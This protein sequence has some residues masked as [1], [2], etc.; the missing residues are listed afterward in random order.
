MRTPKQ[1]EPDLPETDAELEAL[2]V[3]RAEQLAP[4][5]G[6]PPP[7]PDKRMARVPRKV[8]RL[9]GTPTIEEITRIVKE[10]TEKN[11][12]DPQTIIAARIMFLN[13][14]KPKAI[15]QALRLKSH[16]LTPYWAAWIAE[17]KEYNA[18]VQNDAWTVGRTLLEQ[19]LTK[20]ITEDLGIG[21]KLRDI[22][23]N[24]L[25]NMGK[26]MSAGNLPDTK[27]LEQLAKVFKQ[28]ADVTHRM[29]GIGA[30][31][32]SKS[33]SPS[34]LWPTRPVAPIGPVIDVPSQ[35]STDKSQ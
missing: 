8:R 33:E 35:S 3:T 12:P 4:D 11:G 28:T 18:K 34:D 1:T 13:G 26:A 10:Q 17:K 25:E 22:L 15:C 27:A 21:G 32:T 24:A 20:I 14:S 23:K 9:T 6:T 2:S 5:D 16:W 30:K 31:Q 29:A 7:A 19:A